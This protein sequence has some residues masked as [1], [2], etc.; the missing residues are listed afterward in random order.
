MTSTINS[1]KHRKNIQ[2]LLK[3]IYTVLIGIVLLN[4]IHA[5]HIVGGQLSYRN[6]GHNYYEV[7]IV[8]R[9]DCKP[10]TEPF[11]PI[12]QLGIFYTD[13]QK[14]YNI[15]HDGVIQIKLT[16]VE[17]L[18]DTIP[19]VC[20]GKYQEVC[21]Q[22][23]IYKDTLYLPEDDYNRGYILVYQRCCRNSTLLNIIDPLETGSTYTATITPLNLKQG[24]SN[25]YFG[26]KFPP[27]YI[28]ANKPFL[29]NHSAIDYDGDSLVY[30]LCTPY[31]GKTKAFPGGRPDFPPY[32]TVIWKSPFSI[33]NV[34][35]SP[36]A[37]DSKTGMITATPN[38][39]GQFVV[40]IC[41]YEYRKGEL[42]GY[43][44]RDFELNIVPCGQKP[45]AAFERS[46]GLCD[47]LKVNFRNLSTDGIEFTWYFDWKSNKNLISKDFNPMF[48]YS[49][50]GEYE[51]V[52]IA[53]NGDCD[54]TSHLIIK[55]I[56]PKLLADFDYT[57]SCDTKVGLQIKDK[58]SSNYNI[59]NR[60][61]ML[62][63]PKD[64]IVSNLPDPVFSLKGDGKISIK[65]TITDENGC[66]A[67]I[68]KMLEV[69]IVNVDLL[70]DL[71][72]C[73]GDSAKLV[74]NPDPHLSYNWEP[75]ST[76]NLNNPSDPFAKPTTKTTYT[77]TITDGPCSV[78]KQVTVSVRD[79]INISVM[80]DTSICD[81]LIDL[82]AKSDSATTFIWSLNPNFI[83]VLFTGSHYIDHINGSKTFYVKGGNGDQCQDSTSITISD[84]SVKLRYDSIYTVCVEDT[85]TIHIANLNPADQLVINWLPNSIILS[86]L[87]VLNPKI[88][89]PSPGRYVLYFTIK[90]QFACEYSDSIVINAVTPPDPDFTIENECGS[91]R[92]K[93]NATSHGS[94]NWDF[95]DGMGSSHERSTSYEYKRH[96]KYIVR[97]TVDSICTRM[98]QKE[99]T[100]VELKIN[101]RDT[102]ISCNGESVQLNPGG[103]PKYHYEWTP[104]TGLDNPTS[105][106]P[107][108]T[109]SVSTKYYV[110]ITD[111]D[112]PDSCSL[113]DTICV[114]VP[115][116]LLLHAV[117]DTIL[118]EK[119]KITLKVSSNQNGTEYEWCDRFNHPIGKGPEI[120]VT[121]DSTTFYIV[122]AFDPYGCGSRDTVYVELFELNATLSGPDF[123]C[124]GDSTFIRV[125]P[126]PG[127]NYHY[128]WSPK[129]FILGSDTSSIVYVKP[130]QT[131]QFTV[132]ISNDHHCD[133]ELSKTIN[134]NNPKSGLSVDAEPDTIVAGQTSQLMATKHDNWKYIW[135]PQD[136]TLNDSSIYNPIAK[137]IRTTVYT[138]TVTDENGCTATATIRVVVKTCE[139]SFFIP[140][141]F[142]P[143]NDKVNDILYVRSL[144]NAFL[145]ME[146][147]IYNRWGTKVF[148][149]NNVND[150]WDGK[151]KNESLTPDVYGYGLKITCPDGRKIAKK[152]NISI[153]K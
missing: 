87:N 133:W 41:A 98:L 73:R 72:I 1:I 45:T 83:P 71:T 112:F 113:S 111:P 101:L 58:S 114:F 34:I 77:V 153:I 106:N 33:T 70:P 141:A 26:E 139:E 65:L 5:T 25:P 7:T 115:A 21:V 134:V 118:C 30:N 147:I 20:I 51:V 55:V 6:L 78:I 120:E 53:K 18:Q 151:F 42:I 46:S 32:D 108:A 28:C 35:G 91:L 137:P 62:S 57:L 121:P 44:R 90:N 109:V 107:T 76:L 88:L 117:P 122:K 95:G 146:L 63:G 37:I 23:T 74:K 54:D 93:V 19:N 127:T 143:N 150:G 140:N 64:T 131:T 2:S 119:A 138:V 129:D 68:T 22:Q 12:A 135:K 126:G 69:K 102:V 105:P 97:L 67:S 9:R 96:G 82:T 85:V 130:D 43:S 79:K 13:N 116:K 142:S 125:N 10:D 56:D 123:I 81:G 104:A 132:K 128:K 36:F 61:W 52:L 4:P 50:E 40:G 31:K 24:N 136:G 103:D 145:D 144:P 86:P 100:I 14:A 38:I 94:I 66:T 39:V 124:I 80:G 27:I 47:G 29:F 89:C 110:K 16:S 3:C 11:D 15:G 148:T 152:G 99:I 48:T 92:I 8:F 75:K 84:H 59:T 149:S 49:K 60:Q 17:T